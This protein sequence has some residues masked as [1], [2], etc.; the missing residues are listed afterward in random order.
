[1]HFSLDLRDRCQGT[2]LDRATVEKALDMAPDRC[3]DPND[4]EREIWMKVGARR[5]AER[6]RGMLERQEE[7]I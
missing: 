6:L 5:L 4:T 3:A 1:M 2:I 7:I